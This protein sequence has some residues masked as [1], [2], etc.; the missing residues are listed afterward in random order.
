MAEEKIVADDGTRDGKVIHQNGFD[1]RIRT[2]LREPRV[3][4]EYAHR[5]KAH[6]LKQPQF[7]TQRCQ[8]EVRLGGHEKFAWMGLE[9]DDAGGFGMGARRCDRALD[10]GLM[11][12]VHAVEIAD[13]DDSAARSGVA[14]ISGEDD[15]R[16]PS[17]HPCGQP[18]DGLALNDGLAINGAHG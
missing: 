4:G 14:F 17:S 10:Q 18:H 3:E 8:P 5:I 11:A 2:H 1:E 13:G 12:A 9:H 15:H 16:K 7:F 6:T